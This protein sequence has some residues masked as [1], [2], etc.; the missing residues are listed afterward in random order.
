[1]IVLD[2]NVVSELMRPQPASAVLT[3]MNAQPSEQVWL[4]SVVVAEL[5]YGVG[6]LPDGSRK[7]QLSEAIAAMVFEEFKGRILPFDTEAAAAYAQLV[8]R[9]E[10]KGKPIPMGDAQI[11]AICAAH[12]AKLATRNGRDFSDLDLKLIDPWMSA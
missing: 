10:S 6:R 5:L 7:Q 1:M 12:G 2:T 11:G 8:V 3:W 4:C 9:R